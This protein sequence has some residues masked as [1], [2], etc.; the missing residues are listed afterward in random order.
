MKKTIAILLVCVMIFTLS[1]C[2]VVD[3]VIKSISKTLITSQN[4]PD[5]K[6]TLSLYQV[7]EPVW[8]FGSVDAKL[9]LRDA[10]GR[11]IDEA[12]FSLANDG[13]GV[14]EDNLYKVKWLDEQVIVEMDQDEGPDFTVSLSYSK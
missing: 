10:N 6:Y 4:S 5:G 1:G 13:A 11:V 7:G 12:S 14:H 3:L 2:S 8:S 9:V